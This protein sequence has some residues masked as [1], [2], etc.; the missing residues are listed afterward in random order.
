MAKVVSIQGEK[1]QEDELTLW[2]SDAEVD[3]F[4]QHADDRHL[5]C[6]DRARHAYRTVKQAVADGLR[7]TGQTADGFLE[8]REICPDCR[9]VERVELWD[10]RHNSHN[11]VTRCVLVNA[12][13]HYVDTSY[14]NA[15]GS[16]RMK[17]KQIREAVASLALN[18]MSYRSLVQD[19]QKTKKARLDE[20][21]KAQ[22]ALLTD[23]G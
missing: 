17:P 19:A 9:A 5:V 12:Y 10:V 14:Q 3:T 8:R 21:R 7:F 20:A 13:T 1:Q 2:A 11:K 18:G 16:G 23:A 15:P 22:L 4:V 6:R